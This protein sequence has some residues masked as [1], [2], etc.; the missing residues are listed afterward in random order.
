MARAVPRGHGLAGWRSLARV[1]G[2]WLELRDSPAS[3]SPVRR[4]CPRGEAAAH[5]TW[6]CTSPPLA[7]WDAPRPLRSPAS[8]SACF[9]CPSLCL[10]GQCRA[11]DEQPLAAG[12]GFGGSCPW[13][14]CAVMGRYSLRMLTR[15]SPTLKLRRETRRQSSGSLPQRALSPG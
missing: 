5:V 2:S 8:P 10:P 1:G 14:L 6:E 15:S 13:P 4:P 3:V 9:I 12:M 7:A 11:G